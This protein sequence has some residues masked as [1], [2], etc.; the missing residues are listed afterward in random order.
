[1][2]KAVAYVAS[3]ATCKAANWKTLSKHMMVVA[4]ATMIIM[5]V[6][7]FLFT[8]LTIAGEVGARRPEMAPV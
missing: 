2:P 3:V 5:A 7:T 1:M 6:A 4:T 8:R